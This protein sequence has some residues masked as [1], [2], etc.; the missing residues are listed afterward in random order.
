[1]VIA[2]QFLDEPGET[3]RSGH[4]RTWQESEESVSLLGVAASSGS[5]EPSRVPAATEL[6]GCRGWSI[7]PPGAD[8]GLGLRVQVEK[9]QG[10]LHLPT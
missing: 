3:A 4:Q 10:R 8:A 9:A 5:W 2:L 6:D 7:L 1:M